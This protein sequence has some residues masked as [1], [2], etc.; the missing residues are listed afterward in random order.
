MLKKLFI[1]FGLLAF[2]LFARGQ[3]ENSSYAFLKL[4]FSARAS[5]LGGTNVSA[6]ADDLA[7]SIHNP[8]LLSFV[9]DRTLLLHYM[10]YMDGV[11]VSGAGFSRL[12]GKRASWAVMAQYVDYGKLKE[13]TNE[14]QY[15]GTFSAKDIALSGIY[16]YN[17]SDYW[18]GGVRG[19][20]I[21]GRYDTYSSVAIGVD[22]GLNY[23]HP[24]QGFS[25]SLVARHLGGQIKSFD[26]RREELP[27]EVLLGV[28]KEME[29]A[30]F[31]FSLTLHDL[32]NWK[33]QD[34]SSEGLGKKLFNHLIGSVEFIPTNNFYATA[35]YNFL[36]GN[37]M[38]VN[39][40]GHWA[41]FSLGTGFSIKRLKLG[42]AYAKYHVNAS[43]FT[44]DL[45]YSL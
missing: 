23:Y 7:M 29:H 21:Y 45:S 32:T 39:G 27:T 43:S 26:N 9:T 11:S 3:Y 38:K 41:G 19:N 16:S 30:P 15:I 34:S 14:G 28:S 25:L 5:A 44:F 40:S 37:E 35:S 1:T 2:A 22:L 17:L 10:K 24:E 42:L 18:S 36:R 20:F 12:S 13:T 33:T 6:V 8:A 4:P 31:R